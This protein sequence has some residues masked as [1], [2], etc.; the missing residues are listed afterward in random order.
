MSSR[1]VYRGLQRPGWQ[2]YTPD[3]RGFSASTEP[4]QPAL[5][6]STLYGRYLVKPSGLV[7]VQGGITFGSTATFGAN[8]QVYGIR[9][10]VPA[11]R[12]SGGADLPIGAAW[13]WQ[14]AAASPQLN[15]QLTPT[16]MD[17]IAGG[18]GA[19]S[20]EDYWAQLFCPYVLALGT[21]TITSGNTSVTIT[22]GL[23]DYIPNASDVLIV[24][25]ATTSNNCLPFYVDTPTATTF[26]VHV[27]SNP[28]ASGFAFSW[29]LRGE[30]NSSA[31]FCILANHN[32][33]WVWASGHSITWNLTYEGRR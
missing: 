10:P 15:V 8:D 14:G 2:E 1:G 31:N 16:L 21:G 24:P 9:L 28:G 29:K 17:P 30:P 11:N 22:H 32:R 18:G 19:Q 7:V 13:A 3:L 20:N 12:S 33:P 27:K 26:D 6:N 4:T 5:G 23:V 25:T